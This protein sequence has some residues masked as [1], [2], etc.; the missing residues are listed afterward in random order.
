VRD[1]DL[2]WKVYHTLERCGNATLEELSGATGVDQGRVAGSVE[3]LE[4]NLII[5][6]RDEQY[7]LLS[8]EESILKCQLKYM[9]G[10]GL[11]IEG[12]VIKI[13]KEDK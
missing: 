4:N 11:T 10:P 8:L 3:R 13:K 12:G 1:E 2:D 9:P 6:K 5:E 7:R